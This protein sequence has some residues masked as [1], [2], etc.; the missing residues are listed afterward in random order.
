MFPGR[1][2]NRLVL[3]GKIILAGC[4]LK[5]IQQFFDSTFGSRAQRVTPT[6]S[7]PEPS[8]VAS[9]GL[10]LVDVGAAAVRRRRSENTNAV[11]AVA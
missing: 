8:V 10:G 2:R 9:L 5:P 3:F 7:V 11:P 6:A 4:M 1:E